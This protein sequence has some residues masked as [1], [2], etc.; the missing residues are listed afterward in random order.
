[1]EPAKGTA[2]QLKAEGYAEKCFSADSAELSF[3]VSYCCVTRPELAWIG[4]TSHCM[5]HEGHGPLL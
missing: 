1:M 2:Q 5:R 3:A 4:Y